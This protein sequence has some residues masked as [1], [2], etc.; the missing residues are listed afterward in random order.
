MWSSAVSPAMG[1]MPCSPPSAARFAFLTYPGLA[2]AQ[3]GQPGGAA[4]LAH[5]DAGAAAIDVRWV[6]ATHYVYLAQSAQ[7][8]DIRLGEIGA[9]SAALTTVAGRPPAFDFA[10]RVSSAGTDAPATTSP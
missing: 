7:G 10:G 1:W 2:Q 5:D 3:I 6:D 8:W 9:P 4:V